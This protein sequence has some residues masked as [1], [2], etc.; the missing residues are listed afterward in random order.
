MLGPLY[1]NFLRHIAE[2]DYLPPTPLS[3]SQPS[4]DN[5]EEILTTFRTRYLPAC[6][7]MHIPLE[8]S[9]DQFRRLYPMTYK[10]IRVVCEVSQDHRTK[11]E[12]LVREE[13][14]QLILIKNDR[15]FDLL[16]C[17]LVCVTW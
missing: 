9:A 6:P 4:I 15:T 12:G 3:D 13:L 17:L 7:I 8:M 10:A 11:I 5:A 2:L 1:T 14:S 16:T